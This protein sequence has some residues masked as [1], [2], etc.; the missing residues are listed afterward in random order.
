[1]RIALNVI[2]FAFNLAL[3]K[4]YHSPISL[5]ACILSAFTAVTLILKQ[6]SDRG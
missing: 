5:F 2:L 3:Y 1:M 6:I 4:A